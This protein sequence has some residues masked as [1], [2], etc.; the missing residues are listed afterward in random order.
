MAM[1]NF[2]NSI[3]KPLKNRKGMQVLPGDH[4]LLAHTTATDEYLGATVP[5]R[6]VGMCLE[7]R[8]KNRWHSLNSIPETVFG[9]ATANCVY[10]CV[11]VRV[12]TCD[13]TRHDMKGILPHTVI[14]NIMTEPLPVPVEPV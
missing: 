8:D 3:I 6:N 5:T 10:V 2:A 11:P 12:C 1:Y 13:H 9:K 14:V 4:K 7:D